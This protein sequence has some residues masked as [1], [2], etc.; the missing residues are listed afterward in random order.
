MGN[1]VPFFG[2]KKYKILLN[3]L[4]AAGKTMLLYKLKLNENIHTIPTIGFNNEEIIINKSI[5]S[6]WDVGGASKL[7]QLQIY[8]CDNLD[9]LIT[10]ID[11]TDVNR[12]YKE[13]HRYDVY[14][15]IE[16]I[17]EHN[18]K[19]GGKKFP[20]LIFANKQDLTGA[21][22]IRT[23]RDKIKIESLCASHTWCI[24][25]CCAKTGDGLNEGL[26]WLDQQLTNKK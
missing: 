14:V 9:A 5:F 22:D 1:C 11:S 7:H 24:Q 2:R 13:D 19:I 15:E 17:I 20:I 25:P 26:N 4:D 12:M 6:I 23:I 18:E 3:G 16:R 10:V 21:L 8:Y